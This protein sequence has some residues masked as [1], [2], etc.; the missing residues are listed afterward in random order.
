[1]KDPDEKNHMLQ[2]A[3]SAYIIQQRIALEKPEMYYELVE[4][5]NH[6][7]GF[8]SD[9]FGETSRLRPEMMP[10]VNQWHALMP[11]VDFMHDYWTPGEVHFRFR[12][13]T[14]DGSDRIDAFIEKA[15]KQYQ[16]LEAKKF[17]EETSR[18]HFEWLGVTSSSQ[19]VVP[20]S[21]RGGRTRGRGRG[22]GG[23]RR[24]TSSRG[25]AA[26]TPQSCKRYLASDATTFS[27]LFFD[28]K[29]RLIQ[30]LNDFS[31]RE[32]KFEVNRFAH[33]LGMFLHGPSGSG[34]TSIT[35]AISHYTK[36]HIVNISLRKVKTNK[37]LLEVL[38]DLKFTVAGEQTP[39]ELT[40]K[41]VVFVLEDVDCITFA[42][43]S[44]T[45]NESAYWH[46]K[47]NEDDP[48][49]VSGFL[50]AVDGMVESPGRMIVMTATHHYKVHPALIRPGRVQ[51]SLSLG[52]VSRKC[53]QQMLEHYFHA[54]LNSQQESQLTSMYAASEAS[55][56]P[57][58]MEAICLIGDNV[59]AALLDLA[60]MIGGSSPS[61]SAMEA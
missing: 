33:R 57:A 15:F 24:M 16:R 61:A 37:E 59:D 6:Q 38:Q 44:K 29:S 9:Y 23:R 54:K 32:G 12:S 2:Q 27:N 47:D 25:Q 22:R 7:A 34:K 18:Y 42:T 8:K 58:D 50:N 41:D 30:T 49:T 60:T 43:E 52:T 21:S 26:S 5:N 55:L 40:F 14:P 48:L 28:E 53:A 46:F 20:S 51:L 4:D 39:M 19:S 36:R 17:Q 31:H 3:V 35:K 1:M 11:D 13:S 56:T 45:R 10:P